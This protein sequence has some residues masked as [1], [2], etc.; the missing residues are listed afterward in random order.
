M[1]AGHFA[2]AAATPVAL[3]PVSVLLNFWLIP[4]AGAPGAALAM[5]VV[6]TLGMVCGLVLARRCFGAT[7]I[8]GTLVRVLVA[9]AVTGALARLFAV[10]L[11]WVLPKLAMLGLAYLA[12]LVL[13]R[14]LTVDDLKPLGVGARPP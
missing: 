14:E 10:P 8:R 12:L 11:P 4:V 7:M 2:W 5:V 6:M 3:V 13:L 9:A 1:A